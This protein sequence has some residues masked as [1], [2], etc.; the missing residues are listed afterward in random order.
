MSGDRPVLRREIGAVGVAALTLN[1]VMGSGL[2]VI[3]AT[4]GTLGVWAPVTIAMCGLIMGAVTLAF[5]EA[6]SRVPRAG[7]VYGI[8]QVA[9]GPVAASVVGG[10]IWLSG[11]L[12]AAGILAAA[13]DQVTPFLP[14]LGTPVIRTL[15]IM[16]TCAAFTIIPL[17]GARQSALASEVTTAIKIA[18]LLLFVALAVV[19]PAAP[20]APAAPVTAGI[21]APLL[22]LGIYLY[23]G[24]E[25]GMV[26]NGEVR[27][28]VRTLPRALLGALVVYGVLAIALQLAAGH[29]LGG[30]LTGS[31][32]PLVAG[33]ARMNG[34]LPAVMS[35]AAVF[36]MLGSSS[37]LAT[38]MPRVVFA[39]SR[40]GLLP[41]AFGRVHPGRSTPDLAIIVQG[42]LVAILASVGEFTPLT[43]AAS[44]ASM[45]VYVIGCG[46]ALVLRRRNVTED[47]AV[48][49]WRATPV[50]AVIG[51]VANLL[52]IAG[53]PFAQSGA[54]MAAMVVFAG[55][56]IVR[57]PREA[58]S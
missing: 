41:G 20:P 33:A 23:A 32:A 12:A 52:I 38:A 57:R 19:A 15:A 18:P 50:A 27:D 42:V 2:F 3:P 54:L 37:G 44:L 11:T 8:V 39:M 5:A 58:T 6:S 21:A 29:L 1:I 25:S 17:R 45:A 40:D 10:M 34:W 55:L 16:I 9:L 22:I 53:A 14:A 35:G 47:G 49:A 13:I 30:A 51:I 31:R 28:P 36:S 56:A 7:G 48:V 4:M 46:A 24:V 26:M 43:V